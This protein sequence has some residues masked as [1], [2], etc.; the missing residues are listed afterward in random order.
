MKYIATFILWATLMATYAQETIVRGKIYYNLKPLEGVHIQNIDNQEA[1]TTDSE[2]SFAIK[3]SKG[4]SLKCT[5]MGKKTIISQCYTG[6]FATDCGTD[7]D[8]C[9]DCT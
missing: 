6:G 2:G 1:T 8:R 3:A 7:N 4:H 5:F 9:N